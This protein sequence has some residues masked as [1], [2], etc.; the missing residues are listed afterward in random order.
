[1]NLPASPHSPHEP[2]PDQFDPRNLRP[3]EPELGG[4]RPGVDRQL[5]VHALHAHEAIP[6]QPLDVGGQRGDEDL[7]GVVAL[8]LE[9]GVSKKTIIY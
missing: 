5:V 6:R 3:A 4:A 8:A 1:M 7:L 2:I 9:R